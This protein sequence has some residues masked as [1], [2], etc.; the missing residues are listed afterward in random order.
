MV[1]AS[2][3]TRRGTGNASSADVARHPYAK[4]VQELIRLINDL[5]AHGAQADVDLPRIVVIGN[6]SAGKSSLVEAMSKITVPRSQGTCTRCP[7]ECRMSYSPESFRCQ[8]S[9]RLEVDELGNPVKNVREVK[10]GPL[11]TD[12]S[13]LEEMLRRAQLAILNPS[14]PKEFFVNLDLDNV[15]PGQPPFGMTRQLQFSPNVICVD[16]SSPVV[17]DLTFIDLPGII[18]NVADGEDPGNISLIEDLVKRQITGNAIILLTVTMRDDVHNQRAA[19]LAREADPDGI[20]TIG[21]L[22]KPDTLQAGEHD[23]WLDI[24]AGRKHPLTHGYYV[25]KLASAAELQAGITYDDNRNREMRFFASESPWCDQVSSIRQR[26]GVPNLTARL[27]VLL[28][29]LIEKTL[30]QLRQILRSRLLDT[31]QELDVLPAPPSLDSTIEL[32]KL[33][34]EFDKQLGDCVRG[35]SEHEGLLQRCRPA[36]EEFKADVK[37]TTPNFI[38][39]LKSEKEEETYRQVI[40]EMGGS[41]DSTK[42]SLF[43]DDVRDCI[44]RTVTRELP[45]NTPYR[46]KVHFIEERFVLWQ[47]HSRAC[48][49]KVNDAYQRCLDDLIAQTFG[50]YKSGGL[51]DDVRNIVDFELKRART[52]TLDRIA[53]LL[54][55]E[56]DPFTLNDAYLCK[57]DKF[58]MSFRQQRQKKQARI[59][60]D[61]D[62][63]CRIL[64]SL[65]GAGIRCREEDIPHIGISELYEQELLLMAEA[66]AFFRVAY[67]RIID[68]LPRLIDVDFLKGLRSGMNAALFSGLRLD[69]ADKDTA[70]RYLSED[71]EIT[72]RRH[73]LEDRRDRLQELVNR[74]NRLASFGV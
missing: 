73:S 34:V 17:T 47:Q 33:L 54:E 38:P 32:L 49:E 26:M 42:A 37:T 13:T 16:I 24:L 29:Q 71:P 67:K 5:R 56:K 19:L 52:T 23:A 4:K 2:S 14:V 61:S 39:F 62:D 8:I 40:E 46:A 72:H 36:Y 48:F 25:A 70:K 1:S 20:R 18:S 21:V 60:I 63:I 31:Q 66:A 3:G 12:K 15:Q 9:L 59:S 69:K 35:I 41:S 7:M 45:H 30:P 43:L 53:W 27:S 74:L 58:F 44:D 50:K 11:L 65:A 22:T 51:F 6:Q 57:R 55:L 64:E 68:N 28:S 10:F